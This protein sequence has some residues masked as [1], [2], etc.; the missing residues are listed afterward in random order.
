MAIIGWFFITSANFNSC[1]EIPKDNE[2]LV[3]CAGHG[4]VFGVFTMAFLSVFVVVFVIVACKSERTEAGSRKSFTRRDVDAPATH[5]VGFTNRDI[6]APAIFY[7]ENPANILV[8]RDQNPLK[9]QEHP[10]VLSEHIPFSI[11]SM[12]ETSPRNSLEGDGKK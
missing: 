12:M 3:V 10:Q 11:V 5:Y 4:P 7:V 9:C 6:D 2:N 1:D 8:L